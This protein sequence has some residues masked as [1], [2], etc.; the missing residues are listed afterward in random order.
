MRR[1][2]SLVQKICDDLEITGRRGD[3]EVCGKLRPSCESCSESGTEDC[4]KSFQDAS[5]ADVMPH[6]AAGGCR[7]DLLE[8]AMRAIA[9]AH[10][11]D[12]ELAGLQPS[13][14]GTIVDNDVFMMHP[15]CWCENED[16]PWCRLHDSEPNFRYKPTGLEV[17]WYKYIGRGMETNREYRPYEIAEMLSACLKKGKQEQNL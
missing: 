2:N 8:A 7:T 6:G 12:D 13:K 10:A 11:P 9:E 15:Y 3:V 14:Y 4:P 17:R 5:D 1:K 16:C